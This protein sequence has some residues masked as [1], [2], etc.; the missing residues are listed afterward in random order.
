MKNKKRRT[1]YLK[2]LDKRNKKNLQKR[3]K[4]KKK[5]KKKVKC[6]LYPLSMPRIMS[7]TENSEQTIDYFNKIIATVNRTI[8]KNYKAILIDATEV[9]VITID[10]LMYLLAIVISLKNVKGNVNEFRGNLPKNEN[11]KKIFK[12]SGFLNF[13]Q[14]NIDISNIT[15]KDRLQILT[16]KDV[17]GEI[18]KKLIKFVEEH[19]GVTR[20]STK[21]LYHMLIELMTN[22]NNHAYENDY[23]KNKWYLYAFVNENNDKITITFLDTGTGIPYTVSKKWDDKF[24]EMFYNKGESYYIASAMDGEFRTQTQLK[25]RGKGLP[26]IYAHLINKEIVNLKIISGKGKLDFSNAIKLY[27]A[28]INLKSNLQGTVY[29]FELEKERND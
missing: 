9:E 7:L 23:M 8:P 27:D 10:S 13:V 6:L 20:V 19:F 21:F 25:H 11:A 4:R 22:T 28:C 29:Y 1:K 12:E 5:P 14:N 3:T 18:I 16:G 26:D 2:W 24:K 15:N 17:D